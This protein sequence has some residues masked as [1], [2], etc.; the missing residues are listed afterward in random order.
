MWGMGQMCG[1]SAGVGTARTPE[2][3]E[4]GKKEE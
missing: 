3:G 4:M 2:R 1:I